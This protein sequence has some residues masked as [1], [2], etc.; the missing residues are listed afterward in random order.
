[1]AMGVKEVAKKL[2]VSSMRVRELIHD[3]RLEAEKVGSQWVIDEAAVANKVWIKAAG[4]P[5]APKSALALALELE[6]DEPPELSAVERHRLQ[7]HIRNLA[8][9]EHPKGQLQAW[10]AGRAEALDFSVSHED[11]AEL[12]EDPAIRLS[13]VSDPRSGL[14]PGDEVEAYVAKKD[15]PVL[16]KAWFMVPA[17]PGI[18]ANVKLRAVDC[19]PLEVPAVFSAMDL[20]ERPGP[21][22]Q[23][24]ADS[25]LRQVLHAD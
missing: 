20:A 4:R 17:G 6:G 8:A 5:M 21:R 14:L 2:G 25:I 18:Q 24:A 22:E 19:L 9:H 15:L 1:M 16:K 12:R 7:G 10:L 13:G 3:G 11:I 23:A